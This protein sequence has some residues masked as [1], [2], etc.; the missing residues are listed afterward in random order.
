MADTHPLTDAL[1]ADGPAPASTHPQPSGQ[2][3]PALHVTPEATSLTVFLED[4]TAV[5]LHT[6]DAHQKPSELRWSKTL[7]GRW[8]RDN[9]ERFLEN[10]VAP[11]FDWTLQHLRD[12][13]DELVQLPDPR[14]STLL[15]AWTLGTY[16]HPLFL[17]FPRLVLFG[18]AESG[19]TKVLGILK[20]TAWNAF[21]FTSAT[22]ATMYRLVEEYRPTLL[23]DEVENLT[24]PRDSAT[25]A[26]LPIIHAGYKQGATVPR[27]EGDG[28]GREVVEYAVYAPMAI[29]GIK[30][31]GTVT[32]TRSVA[33]PLQ[34][35]TDRNRANAKV[36]PRNPAFAEARAA[37][38]RLCLLG[39]GA[40][41]GS[42]WLQ[43]RDG[44][45][46]WFKGRTREVWGPLLAVAATADTLSASRFGDVLLSLA[47]ADAKARPTVDE[48]G[49]ATLQAVAALLGDDPTVVVRPKV[50]GEAVRAALGWERVSP[51]WAAHQLRSFGFS[52]MS[53]DREGARYLVTREHLAEKAETYGVIL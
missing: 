9:R 50:V 18:Q 16:F 4:K 40:V 26:V 31:V 51:E 11:P 3:H 8:P 15:A 47:E 45:P 23:L 42:D 5:T 39:A 34:R 36:D 17:T 37:C 20:E 14:H 10:P 38:Y 53:K 28:R 1:S 41:A 22:A 35:G 32:E 7:A 33:L 12:L 44:L 48:P 43:D 46:E 21:H 25:R 49:R 24:N 52:P 13:F 2:P 19:K 30:G 6:P 27:T 29:A